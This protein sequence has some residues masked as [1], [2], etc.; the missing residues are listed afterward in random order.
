MAVLEGPLDFIMVKTTLPVRPLPAHAT[1]ESVLTPQ[2]MIRPLKESDLQDLHALR[3]QQEVMRWTSAARIDTDMAESETKLR[4]HLPPND[5]NTLNTAICLRSTGE[6]VG[7]GGCHMFVGEFGWPVIGYMFGTQHWG[8]G[9]ASEFVKAFLGM[10]WALPREEVELS[11]DRG[12]ARIT[13]TTAEGVAIAEEVYTAVTVPDNGGSQKV[14]ERSGFEKVRSWE[15][16]DPAD[17]TGQ[18]METCLGYAVVRPR[19]EELN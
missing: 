5:A 4:M 9:Y 2:L 8:K 3:T 17:P 16:V 11:V 6:F 18:T 12:T 15:D 10:W 19:S 13:G 14:L 1:R 7:Y